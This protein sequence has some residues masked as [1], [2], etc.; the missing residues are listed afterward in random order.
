[1][2]ALPISSLVRRRIVE[3]MACLSFDRPSVKNALNWRLVDELRAEFSSAAADPAVDKIAIIGSGGSFM[4]G[5]EVKFF[6][7]H[8]S[9][10][11]LQPILDFTRMTQELISEFRRCGKPV[12]ACVDGLALGAGLELAVACDS[13]IATPRATLGLPETSLGIYPGLGG[14]QRTPRRI[15]VGLAKWMILT[16]KTIQGPEAHAIGL[17]DELAEPDQ[18]EA[19]AIR[20]ARQEITTRDRVRLS[21]DHARL[22]RFFL[23]HRLDDILAGEISDSPPEIQRAVAAVRRN[24]PIALRLAEWLIDEGSKLQLEDGLELEQEYLPD[25]FSTEDA[26]TGLNG[27][28]LLRVDFQGR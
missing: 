2:A 12:I 4:A 10:G 5:V 25:I 11:Q 27:V 13:I 16:A 26:L 23:D 6:I 1:M 3:R 18:L 24:A 7:D 8:I 28:G 14:T 17:V 9:R 15:G 21:D 20:S 22:E 19:A